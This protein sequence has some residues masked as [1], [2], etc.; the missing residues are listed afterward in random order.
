MK[1][2]TYIAIDFNDRVRK[3]AKSILNLL[4]V[5]FVLKL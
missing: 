1:E 2:K 4:G 3:V 5:I